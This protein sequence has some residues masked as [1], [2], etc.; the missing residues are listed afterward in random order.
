MNIGN[1]TL[2]IMSYIEENDIKFIRMQFCSLDG[3]SRNI[4]ISKNQVENAI[5]YGIPF[6]ASSVIGFD[7][8]SQSDLLLKPDF[9]TI[10][11][12]PWRPQ[13]GKVA[14]VLCDV[15]Y[16][17]GTPCKQDSRYILKQQTDRLAAMGYTMNMG[18]ECEFY[19]FWLGEDGTPTRTLG[20]GAGYCAVAPFDRG[21][22]TRREIIFTL[23]DMGFEIESS[24]HESGAG[25]HEIDF[26]Y[27]DALTCADRIITF[28]NTV[29]TIAQRNGFH[30]TFMP[31][32][33]TG[34]PGS[35]MHINLS[36][37]EDGT[38]IFL[39]ENGAISEEA[40]YFAAGVLAHINAITAV[41]NPLVNS[42][43]RLADGMEAPRAAGWGFGDRQALIR[44]PAAVGEYC[45]ME[46]RSPDPSCN[47]YL[48]FALIIAAGI[49]G[50]TNK[51][52]LMPSIDEVGPGA[53]LPMTLKDALNAM[54]ADPLVA[55]VLGEETTQHY[56]SIKN[57]EWDQ[58]LATVHPWETDKYFIEY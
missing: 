19:L 22:N 48:T 43:K 10:Q 30:A 50:V 20:D 45:R 25:Q 16:P 32:P 41:A 40:K 39:S 28:R 24:H 13:K 55:K 1:T 33:V 56:L 26:R 18:A 57:K 23:E 14:R 9:S 8:E 38:N 4:A 42:Y 35:G 51:T 36:L 37:C 5:F 12:L 15:I 2:D 29:K 34:R 7:H 52:A 11:V 53:L 6:D 54:E 44:V 3:L 31:K 58:Y 47:P 49:E 21:E 17:D 46:L 27:S